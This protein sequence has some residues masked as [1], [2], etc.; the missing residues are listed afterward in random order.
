[1]MRLRNA[2]L[3]TR[4]IFYAAPNPAPSTNFDAV[5]RILTIFDR[6]MTYIN[7]QTFF[8]IHPGYGSGSSRRHPDQIRPK[9]SGSDQKDPDPT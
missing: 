2:V 5:L 3:R 4:I 6:I 1:M 8:C 7:L 9:R